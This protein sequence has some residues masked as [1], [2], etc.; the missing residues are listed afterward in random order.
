VEGYQ[1]R[2]FDCEV[3]SQ[4]HHGHVSRGPPIIPDPGVK[5][6]F[7]GMIHKLKDAPTPTRTRLRFA[8]VA[9]D[10]GSLEQRREPRYPCNDPVEVRILSG[11]RGPILPATALDVSRSG[12]RLALR[13]PIPKG[14]EIEAIV[15]RQ[16]TILGEVCY[17]RRVGDDF[18]AG[19]LIRDVVYPGTQAVEHLHDDQLSLYLVGKGL[20]MAEVIHVKD[21]LAKCADCRTRLSN[22]DAVLH[23]IRRRAPRQ[24]DL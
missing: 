14:S 4:F 20:T 7:E 23:P 6:I 17:C 16:V 5:R 22:A 2:S 9:K 18:H 10:G 13:T 8:A 21:H 15:K 1:S 19:V 11:S 3:G 12:L 24:H